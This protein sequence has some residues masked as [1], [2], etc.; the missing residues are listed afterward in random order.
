[1]HYEAGRVYHIYNQGNNKQ[2]IFFND[3]NYYYFLRKMKKHLLPIADIL[4]YCLMPNHFHWLIYTRPE[5]CELSNMVKPHQ[6]YNT[7]K[8]DP[9]S[10]GHSQKLS[11]AIAI[12]LRSY[13]RGIN[14]HFNRSGSL[15]R[16]TTKCKDGL[17][18]GVITVDGK[19]ASHFFKPDFDYAQNCFLYIHNNPIKASLVSKP[20]DWN[21]CSA[22]EYKGYS[23]R[24]ICNKKLATKL[25]GEHITKFATTNLASQKLCKKTLT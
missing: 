21:F 16:K 8:D 10:K 19:N 13:T 22:S 14:T 7:Y 18:K 3:D 2:Q 5:A 6:L 1:M 12:I 4:C 20:E 11:K 9:L 24:N 23:M 25:L 17:T 15:F